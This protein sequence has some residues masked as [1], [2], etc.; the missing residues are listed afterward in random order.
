MGK[1]SFVSAYRRTRRGAKGVMSIR[2]RENEK[3]VAAIQI[4]KGDELL[5]TT[6]K[7]QLVRIPSDEIR[8]I[9]RASKGVRIMNLKKGDRVTGVSR[10]IEVEGQELKEEESVVEAEAG[11]ALSNVDANAS[12]TPDEVTLATEE[13]SADTTE[14]T[15]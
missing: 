6:E 15:E 4:H 11:T 8:T 7:G 2:L 13:T 9:G 12:A 5:M 3:V 1:R 10:I 14:T